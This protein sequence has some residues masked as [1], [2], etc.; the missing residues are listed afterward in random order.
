MEDGSGW[1]S[2]VFDGNDILVDVSV[3]FQAGARMSQP[4]AP[5]Q[6]IESDE[7]G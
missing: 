5:V 4:A 1:G 2:G 6:Y 7:T 3:K